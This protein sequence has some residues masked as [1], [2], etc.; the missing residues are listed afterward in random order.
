MGEYIY[1]AR[2]HLQWRDISRELRD[3]PMLTDD[4]F[5][6]RPSAKPEALAPPD[7]TMALGDT[8]LQ[9]PPPVVAEV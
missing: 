4:D 6:D 8:A 2:E 5:P 7:K 1:G 9:T 3:L